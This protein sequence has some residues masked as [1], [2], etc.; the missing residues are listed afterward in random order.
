MRFCFVST[1]Y[2][3]FHLGGDAVYVK[4]LVHELADR[5]HE[6]EVIHCIDAFRLLSGGK[7]KASYSQ[8]PNV[9]IHGLESPFG[10]LSPLATQQTGLPLFKRKQ[11]R[12]VLD[13]EFD[14]IQYQNISLVGGPEILR[15]GAG[16]KLYKLSEYWLLCPMHLLFKYDRR[17]CDKKSCV[18]CSLAHRRPPQWW[19]YTGFLRQMTRHVDAFLSPS[20]FCRDKHLQ[21]GLAG[22]IVRLPP[23]V[24]LEEQPSGE[25]QGTDEFPE[26]FFLFV[27]RLEK[28]KGL[29]T[30]I[31]VFR[32]YPQGEPADCRNRPS[33]E[34]AQG[35]GG[36]QPAHPVPR[37]SIRPAP[38]PAL[39]TGNGR[40]RPIDLL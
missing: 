15:Y 22:P 8:H 10:F 27:G 1:F 29:E 4:R 11:I 31:P 12:R 2:P 32:N 30:L 39:S 16:I 35:D 21:L 18:L 19:R 3:P 23:F 37:P 28:I 38:E 5:G 25:A 33:G 36:R 13:R 20:L 34:S 14:V 6:I 24:P 26:P 17:P 7:P 9:K 40:H